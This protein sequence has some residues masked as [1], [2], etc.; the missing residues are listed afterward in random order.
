[1]DEEWVPHHR[2]SEDGPHD[3]AVPQKV[4]KGEQICPHIS[5]WD[6]R[7]EQP[8]QAHLHCHYKDYD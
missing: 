8:K 4:K 5:E 2:E 7:V 6:K 3:V 1:M